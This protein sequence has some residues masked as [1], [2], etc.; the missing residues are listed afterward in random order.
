M[1]AYQAC[2]PLYEQA[3]E[4]LPPA[5]ALRVTVYCVTY[6]W[7]TDHLGREPTGQ[8]HLEALDVSRATYTRHRADFRRA[9]GVDSPMDLPASLVPSVP[10]LPVALRLA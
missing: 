7:L 4:K 2:R 5:A 1:A 9:F 6:R 8:E 10:T 3:A